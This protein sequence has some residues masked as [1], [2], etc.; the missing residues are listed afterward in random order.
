M[1]MIRS[2]IAIAVPAEVQ[3]RLVE[4]QAKLK[5][6]GGRVRWPRPENIHLTLKFLGDTDEHLVDEIAGRLRQATAS[7]SP[8]RLQIGGVGTFPNLKAPRVIWVGA[9]SES[10]HLALLV[11]HIEEQMSALGFS[12]ERR[13]FSA[14][15]TLGRVKDLHGIQPIIAGLREFERFEGGA[16]LVDT[17]FLIKS[18]LHPSGSIYTPLKKIKIG[19]QSL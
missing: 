4:L 15:L 8:F 9:T 17:I 13:P 19:G 10:D 3:Q 5:A 11:R 14:H 2:F 16:F 1:A 7:L 12:K 18:E 6:H